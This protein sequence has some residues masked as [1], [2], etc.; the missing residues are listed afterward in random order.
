MVSARRVAT[1]AAATITMT[2]GL[3]GVA[4]TAGNAAAATSVQ[5]YWSSES[6]TAGFEPVSGNWYTNPATGLAGTPYRLSRQA[7]VPI[8]TATGTATIT[9]NTAQQYQS[10]LGFGSSLE[11]STIYNLSR[12]S[13]TAR[14]R[15][16]RQ[17]LDPATGAG[18]NVARITFGTSDFTGRTFYTYDDGASA[19]L[20]LLV[21]ARQSRMRTSCTSSSSSTP[22]SPCLR[23]TDRTMRA[24]RVMT[25]SSAAST[26][27]PNAG[28]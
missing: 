12:M 1:F 21:R 20:S 2:A 23:P 4:G 16:L 27:T 10:I 8:V 9:A 15:T 14:E 17:L 18:F 22:S 7:D 5:V 3:A 26:G 19:I 28:R 24:K 13:A 6:R 25:N 11:E